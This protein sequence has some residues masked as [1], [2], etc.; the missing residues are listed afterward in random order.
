MTE[1]TVALSRWVL[2]E[3]AFERVVLRVATGNKASARVAEKAGFTYEGTARNAGIV[4]AGRLDL[5]IYSLIR[6]DLRP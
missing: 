6:E 3:A 4:H 1:A 5:A 2:T